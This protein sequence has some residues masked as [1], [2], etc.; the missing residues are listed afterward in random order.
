MASN[1]KTVTKVREVL[2]FEGQLFKPQP[3]ESLVDYFS[4]VDGERL[5][6]FQAYERTM[7]NSQ[8]MLTDPASQV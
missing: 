3:G 2:F 1:R 5:P 6:K 8:L 4:Q 7:A